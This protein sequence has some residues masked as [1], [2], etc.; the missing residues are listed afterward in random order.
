MRIRLSP[1]GIGRW[2]ARRPWLAI[3]VWLAFVVLAVAAL[4]LTG[5]KSLGGGVTGEAARA[6]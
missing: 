4:G 3:A 5:S 1:T 2:S 6:Q